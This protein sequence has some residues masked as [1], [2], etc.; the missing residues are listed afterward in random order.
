MKS[1]LFISM[2]LNIVFKGFCVLSSGSG[3]SSYFMKTNRPEPNF[4]C[5]RSPQIQD[6]ENPGPLQ[7][8]AQRRT[9]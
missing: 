1:N 6:H 3:C 5:A 4:K 8:E 9:M 2:H 7:T